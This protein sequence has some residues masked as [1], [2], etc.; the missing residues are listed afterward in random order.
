MNPSIA[1]FCI[2]LYST[3]FI[4]NFVLC[5]LN[6]PAGMVLGNRYGEGE[7]EIWMDEVECVGTE[8]DL[9]DCPHNGFVQQDCGHHEDVSIACAIRKNTWNF[10]F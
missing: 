7:G 5:L 6:S 10:W 9:A 8:T 3:A 2:G 4:F 1:E